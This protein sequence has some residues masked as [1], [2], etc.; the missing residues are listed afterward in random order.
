MGVM[1]TQSPLPVGTEA[2]L[3][4]FTELVATA[5]ANTQARDELR[6]LA[7]EQ[8]ALRR[9]ALLVAQEASDAEVFTAAGCE[10]SGVLGEA[11][12][13]IVRCHSN[14]RATGVAAWGD[15]AFVPGSQWTL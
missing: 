6:R 14:R 8:A 3:A 5:I 11:M 1:T 15:H 4:N 10:L 2:H 9:L 7:D 12:I 13:E